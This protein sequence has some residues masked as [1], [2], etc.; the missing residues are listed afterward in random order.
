MRRQLP[1]LHCRVLLALLLHWQLYFLTLLLF[2]FVTMANYQYYDIG[3]RSEPSLRGSGSIQA[4]WDNGGNFGAPQPPTQRM[5]AQAAMLSTSKIPPY[6]DPGL[7]LRGYPFRTYL[8]DVRIWSSSSELQAEAQG[9]A[10]VQRL[11]GVA[12]EL[13]RDVDPAALRDGRQERDENGQPVF[14]WNGNPVWVT[15]LEL[16]LRG[17]A[18]KFGARDFETS[19]TSIIELITFRRLPGEP[20]DDC[21][22]RFEIAKRRATDLGDFQMGV[23]GLSWML[24]H[25]LRINKTHWPLLLSAFGGHFPR[26]D[27]GFDQLL[28]KIRDQCHLLERSHSGAMTLEEG[29]RHPANTGSYWVDHSLSGSQEGVD[30]HEIDAF[31]THGDAYATNYGVEV[32]WPS[33]SAGH[34][35]PDPS[36]GVPP[37]SASYYG[38]VDTE[39]EDDFEGTTEAENFEYFGD[40]SG[41]TYDDL[42][43]QYV[44]A[45]RRF[46]K[47]AGRPPRR[48]RYGKGKGKGKSS[49]SRTFGGSAKGAGYGK[50]PFGGGHYMQGQ[51]INAHSLAGGKGKPQGKPHAGKLN[52]IGADGK[53]LLCHICN[54]DKHLIKDCPRNHHWTNTSVPGNYPSGVSASSGVVAGLAPSPGA[55]FHFATTKQEGKE[56]DRFPVQVEIDDQCGLCETDE[57]TERYR[58][59]AF[60]ET[61]GQHTALP[62]GV[63]EGTKVRNPTGSSQPGQS[64]GSAWRDPFP[65]QKSST[66]L[67]FPWWHQPPEAN[68]EEHVDRQSYLVK[69]TD[70]PGEALLVDPGSPDNLVGDRWCQRQAAFCREAGRNPP[71]AEQ[72]EKFKVGG[73]GKHA[74]ECDHKISTPI[75]LEDGTEGFYDAPVIRD[76]DVPALLGRKSLTRQRALIDTFSNKLYLVGHGGYRIQ[77]SPGSKV[78][79]LVRSDTGHLLLP[80]SEFAKSEPLGTQKRVSFATE[81]QQAPGD[82][83]DLPRRE[84]HHGHACPQHGVDDPPRFSRKAE[85]WL[86]QYGSEVG[87]DPTSA[88]HLCAFAANRGGHLSYAEARRAIETG[89]P[90]KGAAEAMHGARNKE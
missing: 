42:L 68:V 60:V 81:G 17:L 84:D 44:V 11:G 45:K 20:I 26:D 72:I 24:L 14:D 10:V 43:H 74:Q 87:H 41:C 51:P 4:Y 62:G 78:Y 85:E 53:R 38:D 86:V 80:C 32:Q 61:T 33:S 73:V 30:D 46:R 48:Q 35:R 28:G 15:G 63:P 55:H 77:M 21:L 59:G 8:K 6:W 50:N 36:Q 16:V 29:W 75:G 79:D 69:M 54:S 19:V 56:E 34:G 57:Q 47:F 9:G 64:K 76:S 83:G 22:G 58:E 2:Y 82:K 23:G 31:L 90:F 1:A 7:E 18:G 65:N 89:R 3:C 49:D 67:L 66:S 52:P 5:N 37:E 70:R 71:Q 27:R 88:Q 25:Q 13:A 12:R 40:F 39:S